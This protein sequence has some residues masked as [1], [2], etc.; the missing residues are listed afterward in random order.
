MAALKVIPPLSITDSILT[1]SNVPET[2]YTAWSSGTTYNI[3][4]RVRYVAT[5]VH[6]VY[7][8]LRAT[9][10]NHDPTTDTSSPPY[11]IEVSPTNRWKMFDTSNTT[12]TANNDNIVVTLTPGKVCNS[13][14]LLGLEATS[15]RVKMTDPTDG[16]VYDET[17]SLNNNGTINNWY[18]YF[19]N[20]IQRRTSI[21]VTDLPA[22]GTAAIEITITNTGL[23]AKCAVCVIGTTQFIGEG[24][25]LGASVGI[26][27]YSRKEK[28][29]FG[30][31][32][33]IQRSYSK[34]AKFS[35][36]ILN[37]Q[38]DSVQDLLVSL[39]TTP[40]VWIGDDRYTSTIVYGFYKDF[41]IV[42]AYHIVSDC[43]LEIEGLT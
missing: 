7:E 38:I 27:D 16:V 8:S 29:D 25:E 24:I 2:D 21:T 40:C 17:I 43:N 12:Q 35:F 9:N 36:P 6:K 11:W 37:E 42:I 5:N 19:F 22:Y 10:L 41:D 18:N 30:N 23:T 4:D 31:Y 20:P 39:R 32:Q 33:L 14:V 1:S 15:V 34:R 26:T 13:V 28:D 3:G